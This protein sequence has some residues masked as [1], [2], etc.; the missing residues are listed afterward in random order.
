MPMIEA[1]PALLFLGQGETPSSE[2][3][4]PPPPVFIVLIVDDSPVDRRLAAA[5][6]A[7]RPGLRP[8]TATGGRD[9][10]AIIATHPPSV[11]VTDLQMPGMNGL[12]L[13]EEIRS[14]YP[15]L[16]VVLMTAY[17][18]E[19]IAIRALRA[20]ASNYVPKKAIGTEL[21][22]T[23]DAVLALA[24]VDHRRRRLLHCVQSSRLSFQLPNDPELIAP[25][26]AMLQED[27]G[28]M[29]VCDN[30]TLTRVGVALQEALS[31]AMYHGNL[32]VSSELRQEDERLFY[33]E[34][35]KRRRI[36][37]YRNR[38]IQV[39]A[40]VDRDV[41]KY[42]IRDEGPGFDTTSLDLPFDP[43]SLMRV[44]G[45]GMILI[46]SFMDEVEHN[47]TGNEIL[48]VKRRK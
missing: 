25:L 48:M 27:L 3:A 14:K 30:N 24:V 34:I 19:D 46:R 16:P 37:P 31:N 15:G 45:R 6:I 35:A 42:W 9:A 44:G 20:G 13:V 12:E 47:K 41:A 7:R 39:F 2:S 43:E 21:V 1:L 40:E 26:I 36:A 38:T 18:S 5:I 8:V 33:A 22:D 17:G 11:V 23:L 32:E 10:L 4:A 28:G 29:G